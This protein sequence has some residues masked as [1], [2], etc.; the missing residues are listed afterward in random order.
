MQL[1]RALW[2]SVAKSRF[3]AFHAA[4]QTPLVGREEEIEL[5]LRR[6]ARA[7]AGNGQVVLL[8]GE[9]GIGKSR[10]TTALQETLESE[11]HATLRWFCS[12]YRQDSALHPMI[13]HLEHAAR[14]D[15]D[16]KPEEK[17]DKLQTS[18]A[19]P[20]APAQDLMLLAE[21]LSVPT[22]DQYA[23]LGL[24]PHQKKEKTLEALLRQIELRARRAAGADGL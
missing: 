8:S 14:F 21:L 5:L 6:W 20:S 2:P 15:R 10:I 7:K 1:W 11:P 16:D 18:L 22:G 4:A 3:E 12:P 9:P 19:Q 13:S 23:P 17:F 24:T